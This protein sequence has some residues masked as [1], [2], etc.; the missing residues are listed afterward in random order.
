VIVNV[1]VGPWQVT[2]PLSN[3]GVTAMVAITGE[4]PLLTAVKDA[5]FP[6]PLTAKPIPGV[7]F[8]QE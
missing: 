8:A 4:V 2:V 7:S 6:E 5:M 1:L 3:C